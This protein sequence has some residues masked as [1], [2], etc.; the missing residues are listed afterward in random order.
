MTR[1]KREGAQRL[2][3]AEESEKALEAE[4]ILAEAVASELRLPNEK[5]FGSRSW[6]GTIPGRGG[7]KKKNRRSREEDG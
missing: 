4:G 1:V 2:R 5:A 7:K 6:G 3:G